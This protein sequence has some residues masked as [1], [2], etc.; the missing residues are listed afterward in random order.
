MVITIDEAIDCALA[1]PE[2]FAF[3]ADF[4]N[5]EKWDPG[6]VRTKLIS[7]D[8]R[9]G[10]TYRNTS[11]FLG[12]NTDLT[13]FVVEYEPNAR[14]VFRGENETV[15]ALDTISFAAIEGGTSVRYQ[16]EFTLKGAAKF[17]EPILR[18]AFF[19]LGRAGAKRMK[20]VLAELDSVG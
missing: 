2:V 18:L 8:G 20:E 5:T 17:L 14:V 6:T 4:T 7:G 12:R 10:S 3:L 16:A 19:R 9:V 15:N 13:Y 1:T 11:R